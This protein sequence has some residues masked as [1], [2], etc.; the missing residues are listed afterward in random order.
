MRQVCLN[1]RMEVV[2]TDVPAP[3]LSAGRALIR[4]AYSLISSGTELATSHRN[5][6][7]V[8]NP[9]ELAGKLG[10]SL[11][12]DGLASTIARVRQRLQPSPR[13]QGRGYLASGV[14]IDIG[15]NIDDLKV[16]DAVAC[17]GASANHA[18]IISVP[19]NLIVPVP[20]EVNLRDACFTA[21]GAIAMQGVR[22]AQVSIGET[23]VVTG[24]GLVGQLTSQLLQAAGCVV[25]AV[26]LVEERLRLARELGASFTI[27]AQSQD[28]VDT[29]YRIVGDHGADAVLVCAATSSSGPVNQAF[30]MCRERGRVIIVGDIGMQIERSSFY[31]KEL[32]LLISRSY[33][34]GRY[35]Y[36]YEEQGLDYPLAYVRWT[37][38]RN[39][40]EFVRLLAS[41]KVHITPL[42]SAEYEIAKASEAY[43]DLAQQSTNLLGVV[44]RYAATTPPN[45]NST[46][47]PLRRSL[48]PSSDKALRIAV[49]G[50]GSFARAY[51]LPN[52]VKLP[53][54]ELAAVASST[55]VRAREVG[56]QFGAQYCTTDY[57]EVLA[58]ES[59]DAVI[60]TTRHNLHAE[61]A[62][63]AARSGKH[64][65]VEKPLA[66]TLQDCEEVCRAVAQANV[67]L[68]VGFN[69]RLAPLIVELKQ[70]LAKAPG[71]KMLIYR[72]NAGTL[73]ADHWTLDPLEGG[74]RILGEACHF[75][76]LFYYLL[77]AEPVRISATQAQAKMTKSKDSAN[78]S[79]ALEF[80][81]G[82]VGTLIYTVIG[83]RR[84]SKERL[85]AFAGGEA[86][87]MDNFQMLESYGGQRS[88]P[89]SSDGDKG[90]RQLL[91]RFCNAVAGNMPL[92]VTAQDGLRATLCSLKAL[93][94]LHTGTFVSLA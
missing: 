5:E 22:R 13:L 14:I 17:G 24:L 56:E 3:T 86:F 90:H 72:V 71:P 76:D 26:D 9:V 79:I 51:H 28:L 88:K 1:E 53:R 44:F 83:N 46:V 35:D 8:N 31:R 91:D 47:V 49:I 69:R 85:E 73:P 50:A 19:R 32:D 25:I 15:E 55:G 87:V 81:D 33:G 75:F 61:M 16:G 10:A 23:V 42:I 63:A 18:E 45:G 67:L 43:G 12:R 34:P 94:S 66:L 89:F 70:S 30:E 37:E 59:I 80:A 65:F 93:E 41:G 82:S 27:N 48:K 84:M 4:T 20:A 64:I 7:S 29:V 60:I 21:L 92:D 36:Q 54:V 62:I 39:M 2:I 6:S 68:T 52:L 77:G 40:V 38:N 78:L 11:R 58:D 57:R 74:G